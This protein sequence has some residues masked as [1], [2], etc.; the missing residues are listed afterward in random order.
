MNDENRS[1]RAITFFVCETYNS[2]ATTRREYVLA[3]RNVVIHLHCTLKTSTTTN[4]VRNMDE[5]SF[6]EGLPNNH[7]IVSSTS[8]VIHLFA[9]TYSKIDFI[10]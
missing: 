7:G 10:I 2:M 3:T 4:R 6:P 9:Y 1:S 5:E 8:S